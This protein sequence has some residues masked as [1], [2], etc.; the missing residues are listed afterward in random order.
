MSSL[1]DITDEKASLL[2]EIVSLKKTIADEHATNDELKSLLSES[3]SRI[4]ELEEKDKKKVEKEI[5]SEKERGEEVSGKRNSIEKKNEEEAPKSNQIEA[6]K[7]DGRV[8][9][10][11]T[12]SV[13]FTR[14]RLDSPAIE[15]TTP[16]ILAV[17]NHV[18]GRSASVRLPSSSLKNVCLD[19]NK[20]L[21]FL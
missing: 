12:G 11:R 19:N 2:S 14:N 15:A 16:P 20:Y 21:T 6:L 3:R 7:A 13:S 8:S 1:K 18:R 17:K 4:K 5:E 10:P 9:R